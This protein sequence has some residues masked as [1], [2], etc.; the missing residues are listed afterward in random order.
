MMAIDM[1]EVKPTI[2]PATS[3]LSEAE[4]VRIRAD[5]PSVLELPDGTALYTRRPDMTLNALAY[6]RAHGRWL[7]GD[8]FK[9]LVAVFLF[10]SFAEVGFRAN[11][12]SSGFDVAP[13]FLEG[14]EADLR[15]VWKTR[16]DPPDE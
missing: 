1:R 4:E 11:A 9:A 8:P 5:Y 2:G 7:P 6:E 14:D 13:F 3:S 16:I 12:Y 10:C 15:T